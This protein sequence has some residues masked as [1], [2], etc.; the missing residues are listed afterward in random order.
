MNNSS[1]PYWLSLMVLFVGSYGGWKWY[2]VQQYEAS[3]DLGGVTFDGPP[4]EEFE[5]TER[6]GE[7]FRSADMK[8][9]VW[10]T[11]FF[12]ASCPGQCPRLNANVKR[13]HD[14]PELEDVTWVSITVDPDN[15]TLPV[16]RDYADRYQADPKRWLFCRGEFDYIKQVGEQIMKLEVTW[17]GHKDYAI[18]IDRTGKVRGMFDATSM[19]QSEKL[20]QL[21]V[22]CLDE[23]APTQDVA[24]V[25]AE[26]QKES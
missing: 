12:F 23:K 1:L 17:R 8:G 5:L 21:L 4:L 9:K 14:L 26:P 6:S 15:D 20:R 11:T 10:V 2:Q 7:P 19:T 16:L 25:A 13:L 18:V 22:K 3:R 24:H